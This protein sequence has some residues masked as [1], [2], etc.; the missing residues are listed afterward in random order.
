MQRFKELTDAAF[1]SDVRIF[2]VVPQF[3]SQFGLSSYPE[4]QS[5]WNT[6]IEDDPSA[7]ISNARGTVSFASSGENS[8]STQLFINT[9]DNKYLDN[10]GFTPIGR[11]VPAGK[12]WGSM[13]V[14][15]E[16]YS[17]YREDPEQMKIR[18]QGLMYLEDEFPKLSYF[19]K[20]EF[21]SNEGTGTAESIGIIE[22]ESSG[23]MTPA[24]SM[25]TPETESSVQPKAAE[26]SGA[27]HLRT[28][29]VGLTILVCLMLH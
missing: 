15:D 25:D 18:Q 10:M 19:V 13:E 26:E 24:D 2:R 4:R 3:V 1:W 21:V 22:A 16:I 17:G 7:G 6:P 5:E 11:V 23:S 29:L 27:S 14:V 12:T 28:C 20:A 9:G 8:R